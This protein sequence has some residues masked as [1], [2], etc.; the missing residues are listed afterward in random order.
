MFWDRF[1]SLCIENNT[2]PNPLAKELGISSGIVT[3]W[4]QGG[5]PNG[6]TLKKIADRLGTSVD[7]LL[8]RTDIKKEPDFNNEA[9][10]SPLDRQLAAL[11]SQLTDEQKQSILQL[12]R[13]FTTDAQ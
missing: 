3:K 4:K 11:I 5:I 13:S 6:D 9:E 2:K 8:G 7:Y 10:L 1:Y 12:I